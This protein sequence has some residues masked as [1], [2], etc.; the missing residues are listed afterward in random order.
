MKRNDQ[1][2]AKAIL[3]SI[4]GAKNIANISH[5]STRLRITPVDK[6]KVDEA[7]IEQIDGVKG[8]FYSG[9]QLQIILGTGLVGRIYDIINPEEKEGSTDQYAGMSLPKKLSRILG[10]IFIPVIPALV[11]TGLFSGIINCLT[12]F[13]VGCTRN[14]ASRLSV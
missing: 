7:G 6:D 11:A 13:H 2:I 4:G 8:Q 12:A 9:N 5:C 10:D 14:I 3:A 1:N